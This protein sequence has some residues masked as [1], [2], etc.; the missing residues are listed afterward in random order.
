MNLPMRPC[1]QHLRLAEP[2]LRCWSTPV[3]SVMRQQV[4]DT[5]WP[6]FLSERRACHARFVAWRG[7]QPLAPQ[8][9]WAS[10]LFFLLFA[11]C[12][13]SRSEE[14]LVFCFVSFKKLSFC[15][16]LFIYP[17]L[18]VPEHGCIIVQVYCAVLIGSSHSLLLEFLF[19]K[20]WLT[21]EGIHYLSF[22]ALLLGFFFSFLSLITEFWHTLTEARASGFFFSPRYSFFVS[23]SFC[24]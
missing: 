7:L 20:V 24:S 12:I 19:P 6:S 2:H 11:V 5:S 10:P 18:P 23:G 16:S 14:M 21:P 13:Y 22:N 8:P 9:H 4:T 1:S 17:F 3:C 15:F